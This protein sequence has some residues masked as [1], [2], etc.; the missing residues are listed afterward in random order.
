MADSS[1]S[2]NYAATA[3]QCEPARSTQLH[4]ARVL[5]H[6]T[7]QEIVFPVLEFAEK[8]NARIAC[9]QCRFCSAKGV[10]DAMLWSAW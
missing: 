10:H 5:A 3:A 4:I 2:I 9:V 6:G 7:V 8:S 1:T